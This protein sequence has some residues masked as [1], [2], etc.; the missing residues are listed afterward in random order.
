MKKTG[1]LLLCAVPALSA[2]LAVNI[3]SVP[4]MLVM[5]VSRVLQSDMFQ[6]TIG[7]AGDFTGMY[8]DMLME[9]SKDK[10]FLTDVSLTTLT[11]YNTLAII[12]FGLFYALK[13]K[14]RYPGK[15]KE[16]FG[17]TS[18]PGIICMFIGVEGI[19]NAVMMVLQALVPSAFEHYADLIEQSGFNQLTIVSTLATLI[20]APISEEIIFRGITFKLARRFTAK[21]WLANLI[22]ATLFGL[23][24]LNLVQG[25][26]AF[27]IG[28]AF[29]WVYSKFHSLWASIIAHLSFNFAGTWLVTIIYG[30]DE[31]LI[32]GKF[33]L[34]TLGSV[35]LC[36][37][38]VFLIK[39]NSKAPANTDRFQKEYAL[40]N[41][42]I[43][44]LEQ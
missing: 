20:L 2:L 17:A 18:I 31:S 26:Y 41:S 42:D 25:L 3:I 30:T 36:A 35:I 19:V 10:Q 37:G 44:L 32:P 23:Y 43:V 33:A 16:A 39:K 1:K 9:M 4:V 15:F 21:F 22:Q 29:G 8:Y 7:Q 5:M 6:S 11:Y 24:H 13:M 38:G 28:L 14:N 12:G 40:D 34:V 27:A